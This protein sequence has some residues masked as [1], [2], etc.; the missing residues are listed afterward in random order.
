MECTVTTSK[1]SLG[2]LYKHKDGG[3]YIPHEI[4]WLSGD[5]YSTE[6]VVYTP[7]DSQQRKVYVR[8]L[9]H[10]M[11]SFKYFRKDDDDN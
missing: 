7:Y 10:F 2:S 6:I 11:S 8:T 4:K 5:W 3:L 1:I 9:E